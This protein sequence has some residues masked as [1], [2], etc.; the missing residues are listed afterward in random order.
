MTRARARNLVFP[1]SFI[2][3][4]ACALPSRGH[5]QSAGAVSGTVTEPDGQPLSG[6]VVA[7][8]G[9]GVSVATS[10]IGRYVLPRVPAGPRR[11]EFRRIGYAVRQ[12]TVI[13]TAG[14]SA[15]ADAVLDPQ[16]IELGSVL[17]EGVSRAPDRMIDA[18]AAV[19]VVR[20][21]S[22]EPVSITG[23]VPLALAR[24]PGLD[25]TQNGMSDFNVNA[26]GFNTMLSHKMLVLQDGRELAT[27]L[28]IRQTWGALA[29][30]LE[31]LGRIE[32]IRGPGSALY[33]AN[34]YNGVI[35]ITTPPAR[36]VVGTKLT[37]GGGELGT[38]RADLRQAGVW[39]HDRFGYRV[40]LGY[41][42]SDD[43]TRSRTAKDSS[44]WKQ[45]YARATATPPSSPGP[46]RVALIGQTTDSAT[47]QALGTPDPLVTVYGSARVDYYAAH[48]SIV[49]LEGGAAQEENPVFTAGSGRSQARR[50]VRP[51]A[52]VAWDRGG[53]GVSAW[54]SGLSLPQGQVRLTTGLPI[55][56]SDGAFHLE[57]RTSHT[58]AGEAGRVVVG[59]SI[60][61]NAVDSKGTILGPAYDDR[62]D[63]YYGAFAQLEY[64]VGLVRVIGAVRWDDA[65]LYA[66]QLSPKA[67]L[68]FTP[69]KN[70][71]LRVS[72]NRA[73]LTPGLP[74]LF[75]AS[76]VGVQ[77]LSAI[78]TQLRADPLVGPALAAVPTGTLFNNSAAVPE[79]TLGNPFLVPQTVTSYEVGYK[80][81]IG[82]RAF[83]TLDAYAA[84]MENFTT[85]NLPAGTTGLNPMY[86]P[87]TAPSDVPAGSRGAVEAAVLSALAPRG[88][89]VQNGLTRLPDGTTAIVLS[90]GNV[91]TVDEWG[92][93]FGSS[94]SLSRALTVSANYTWYNSA[95][96][97]NV[98]DNVL[99]PNTPHNK[100]AISLAYVGR[101]GI[102][103]GVDARIVSRYH[104][105][106]GVWDGD[107]PASQIV[108]L[109]AGYRI[110]PHLRA[111]AN[112]TNL[113]DQQCFQ[114]YGGSVIGRR[115][116]AGA[117]STF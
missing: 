51:W 62:S 31:D 47:G 75:A 2:A 91:G 6:V 63:Q 69:A 32:V 1:V 25:V 49:T 79:S 38:A 5:A 92:V 96:R 4:L 57:G 9:L 78:E 101:Q 117:T 46:E 112:A 82:W 13:V 14:N 88:R 72:V 115:V 7:V 110:N 73:F 8:Q 24:V 77:N 44:D 30:P 20:P 10:A 41:T 26:R 116:L 81:Q 108:N 11:L 45:E 71:A 104:W 18:P 22:A 94:I 90:F 16:P 102:D 53:S 12:V 100:G 15:T 43:W 39:L 21:A 34:A 59:A 83:I 60:Q 76:A 58:F 52:R 74:A 105:T 35:N 55:Y 29:E 42:R 64:R 86:Q 111:Y 54:Y 28:T 68:V 37:L 107:I 103:V 113:F 17:V 95:I 67:A 40:N 19:D 56:N 48:G 36:D 93:E 65:N 23:Q 89:I 66:P 97:H 27:A 80:G 98:A 85:G 99:T 70:H 3:A 109:N 61:D 106:T 84:R 87:W 50:L 114:V 33:G